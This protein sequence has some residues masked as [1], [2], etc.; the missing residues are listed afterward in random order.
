VIADTATLKLNLRWFDPKVRLQMI[1]DVKRVTDSIAVAAGMPKDKMP[2]YVM[3]GTSGPVVNDDELTQRAEPA[4]R[5]ALG[6]DMLKP[7]PPPVMG[8]EDF[9]LLAEPYPETKIL[10]ISIGCGPADLEEQAK[11]GNRPAGNHNPNFK[12]ELP[13][14]ASGMKANAMVLLEMLKKWCGTSS[15]DA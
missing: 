15:F 1:E 7:G 2:T 9:Q 11:K 10:F 5:M 12:V 13:A 8:S 3:R 14:I 4:L 6:K